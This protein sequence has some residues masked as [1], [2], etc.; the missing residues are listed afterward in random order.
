MIELV[1]RI[2]NSTYTDNQGKNRQKTNVCVEMINYISQ[3]KTAENEP[4]TSQLESNSNP[5]QD[6]HDK[7]DND[8][9]F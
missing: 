2:E 6:M 7:I 8:L 1:G 3:V 4:K 5:Y 9:P